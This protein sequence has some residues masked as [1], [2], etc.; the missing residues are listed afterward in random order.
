M[1]LSIN[2]AMVGVLPE[3]AA[4][5]LN[6]EVGLV[7]ARRYRSKLEILRD[8]LA[9]AKNGEKKTHLRG[10]AN[11]NRESFDRYLAFC[12]AHDLLWSQ[13]GSF[14]LTSRAEQ[15]LGVIEIALT[16]NSELNEALHE[17]ARLTG[18]QRG[19]AEG[20]SGKLPSFRSTNAAIIDT[21]IPREPNLPPSNGGLARRR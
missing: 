14:R 7:T 13:N 19:C 18:D 12:V 16:R 11:L 4:D 20:S 10:V 9:A 15:T 2:S 1:G 21:R 17:F 8:V 6:S 3:F 5:D